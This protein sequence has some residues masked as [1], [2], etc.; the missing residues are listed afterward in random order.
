MGMQGVP[1]GDP[2]AD[3]HRVWPTVHRRTHF[4]SKDDRNIVRD[5]RVNRRELAAEQ[6]FERCNRA[7]AAGDKP[8]LDGIRCHGK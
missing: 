1:A 7:I 4:N 3:A 5:E 2:R 8:P 6:Y